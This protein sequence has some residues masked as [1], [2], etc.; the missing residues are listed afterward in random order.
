[1]LLNYAEGQ[2]YISLRWS[3][4]QQHLSSQN[5][6]LGPGNRMVSTA[7]LR[8]GGA[9][10]LRCLADVTLPYKRLLTIGFKL[11]SIQGT[12]Q[13]SLY[14]DSIRAGRSGDRIQVGRDFRHPF[15]LVLGPTQPSIKCVL[16]FLPTG[17]AADSWL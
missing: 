13:S 2:L 7:V 6:R 10:E 11:Q 1:M 17:K 16:G 9:G 5:D 3:K 15:R 4:T 14:S 8:C 12:G